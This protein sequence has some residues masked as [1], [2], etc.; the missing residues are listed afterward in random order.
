LVCA[1]GLSISLDATGAKGDKRGF[2]KAKVL[3][4]FTLPRIFGFLLLLSLLSQ[5]ICPSMPQSWQ[6]ANS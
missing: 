4:V 5:Y 2:D 6:G 1:G 3:S